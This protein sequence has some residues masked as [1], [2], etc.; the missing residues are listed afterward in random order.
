MHPKKGKEKTI[1]DIFTNMESSHNGRW[2]WYQ[3]QK[4]EEPKKSSHYEGWFWD[5]DTKSFK[6]WEDLKF[7]G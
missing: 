7:N 4:E 5:F 3:D 2:N 6:R 1:K